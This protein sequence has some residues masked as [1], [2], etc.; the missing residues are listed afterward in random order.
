[1]LGWSSRRVCS[2][3]PRVGMGVKVVKE[4]LCT[5]REPILPFIVAESPRCPMPGLCERLSVSFDESVVVKQTQRCQSEAIHVDH[6]RTLVRMQAKQN[7]GGHHKRYDHSS[8]LCLDSL[9]F[10][11]VCC[12]HDVDLDHRKCQQPAH[13]SQVSVLS[14]F[15]TC[16]DS[17][18]VSDSPRPAFRRSRVNRWH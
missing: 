11:L 16:L 12:P 8:L 15:F 2:C 1:M 9:G 14:Q 10:C 5:I 17:L 4:S 7:T 13:K 18:A 3:Q 6:H